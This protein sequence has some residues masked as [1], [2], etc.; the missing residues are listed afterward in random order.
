[1]T[2]IA[3]SSLIIPAGTWVAD[4]A[5]SEVGFSVRHAGIANVRGHFRE[6]EAVLVAGEDGSLSAHATIDA[7]SVDTG[8]EYRDAHLR[9]ADFFD[10][11][12]LPRITFAATAVT[13]DGDDVTMR[14]DFT[15]HGETRELVLRGELLGV[16]VDD[17]GATRVGLSLTG[18][19]SRADYG[20]RFNQAL[21]GGN[22]LVGDKVKLAL[23]FSAVR[24]A[25]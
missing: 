18:S 24:Q 6:F 15:L 10:V 17:D 4:P 16:G 8:V 7:A 25:S 3:P 9:S 12:R 21:G 2:I 11:E 22:M 23:E 14:G 20:M 1:M 19:I 5:H 13:I